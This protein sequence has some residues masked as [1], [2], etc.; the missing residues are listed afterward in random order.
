[1]ATNEKISDEK[2][3]YTIT[4]TLD[5]RH[6]EDSISGYLSYSENKKLIYTPIVYFEDCAYIEEVCVEVGS[7]QK[8]DIGFFGKIKPSNL[9][10]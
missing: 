8:I 1:M 7:K 10:G 3:I 9:C 5:K 6:K 2:G 4:G